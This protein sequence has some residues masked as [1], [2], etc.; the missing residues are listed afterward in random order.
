M[1]PFYEGLAVYGDEYE[2]GG[3]RMRLA[4]K[5]M[6]RL[7]AFGKRDFAFVSASDRPPPPSGGD[8]GGG[9]WVSGTVSVVTDAIP[10]AGG[11]VRAYQ[12]SVAFY[13]AMDDDV[14]T[15][16]PRM[17]LTIVFR[18]DLNDSTHGGGGGYVPMFVYVRTVG[19]T[20][21]ASVQNMK[22]LIAERRTE[23]SSPRT[24][25]VKVVRR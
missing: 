21:M 3:V 4:R 12:D 14:S 24:T 22:R 23:G 15:G 13:E 8:G 17:R 20:G 9:A 10:R 11:Y 25:G 5:T 1:D 2:H 19:V 18:I 16:S 6:R 7:V